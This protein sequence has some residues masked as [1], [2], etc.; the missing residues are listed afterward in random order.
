MEQAKAKAYQKIVKERSPK[1]KTASMCLKA[2]LV[3]GAICCVGQ[4]I[5]DFGETI[6]KLP[7]K[8]VAAFTSM[9][10]VFLGGL[11]TGIGIYDKLGSFAGA[12]SIVPITGFANS[13]VAP[14]MEF[15]PEGFVLGLGA[16]LFSIAGPVLVYGVTSSVLVGILSCLFR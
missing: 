12:G 7:E 9:T 5:H 16:K 8:D 4:L 10:L 3:G 11:L 6:L 2:F 13:I 14:A 1:S 15:R